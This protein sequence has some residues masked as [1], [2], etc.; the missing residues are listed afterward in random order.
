MSEYGIV[1]SKDLMVPMRDGVRLAFD[2]YRPGVDGA[3]AEGT[4][5]TIMLHTAYDKATKR[6][7]EIADFFVPRGYAVVLVDMRDRY[8]SEG[9]G[10]YFHSATPHTGRD[11]YD[12]VEWIAAQPWSNG[13]VG[14][15]GSSYAGQ[16]QIRMA[17]ENPPHLTAIWP[18]VVTTN[19]YFNCARE[20]GAFQGQMFWALFIHAQDAQDIAGDQEKIDEVWE[21]L[22]NLRELFRATP[23]TEGQTALRH[24]PPLEQ[25][26]MNYY[27]R[28]AYDDWWAQI[29]CDYERHY[30]QHAD[31]PMTVSS[32]WFDPWAGPDLEYWA[33]MA[34]K[35]DSPQRVVIGPWSHV[36]MR[37][38][39]TYCHE[40]DFGTQSVWGVDRYFEEQLEYFS[41][42]LPND[43]KGHPAD[44]PP[45]QLF[46]MGGGSGLKTSEGK[47]DHGGTWRAEHE[48][49]L[50]RRI[51]T[52]YYL[53]G[54]GDLSTTPPPSGAEP[55]RY[56]F[57]PTHPVPTVGGVYCAIGELPR[58]GPGMEPAWSRFLHP[59]LRLRDLLTPG[60]ADQREAPQF[61]GSEEPFPRLSER[62]DVLVFQTEPLTQPVEVTGNVIVNLWISSS[63]LDTDFTAKVID[64]HPANADYPTGFDMLLHDSV[65]R[66]RYRE[67]FDH[68]VLLTPG[69]IVPVTI[70]IPATSNL[71]DVGHRIRIDISSSN[72]PRLDV[73]PN[74]G[75]AMGRH[76]HQVVAHQVVYVDAGHPS[77]ALLP[78]IPAS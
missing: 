27:R 56:T 61:F 37:G 71:F 13:R 14:T 20:G 65:I 31:V 22:K 30:P 52:P 10:T 63:A 60:P 74:T 67:G 9:S 7:E 39:A 70:R 12:I 54:N 11:G 58:E 50:A 57:D 4:F 53:H 26:L 28:G 69:E 18:D 73:N 55:C 43:A 41:R 17:L 25:T 42:W 75:E 59:V 48:W 8:R 33:A 19:N 23:W 15:C 46:V 6:Y 51:D 36:G 5:P 32:G 38:E 3:Y 77:H 2:V 34:A 16:V 66:C 68:E 64:V 72:W 24:V 35:N 45:I 40:V 47:L 44:E 49:P 62:P 21:D 1:V 78:V 76:T 29:S